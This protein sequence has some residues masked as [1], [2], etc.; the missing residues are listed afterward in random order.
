LEFSNTFECQQ[1]IS[2]WYSRQSHDPRA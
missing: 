1:F 2:T